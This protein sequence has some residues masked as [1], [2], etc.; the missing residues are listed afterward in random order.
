MLMTV[1]GP[2]TYGDNVGVLEGVDVI[3]DYGFQPSPTYESDPDAL[4]LQCTYST[5]GPKSILTSSFSFAVRQ[6]IFPSGSDELMN[7]FRRRIHV[8]TL[9][10][11]E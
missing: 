1:T 10:E 4:E 9:R 2:T 8:S 3:I 6:A 7:L 11:E 5:V